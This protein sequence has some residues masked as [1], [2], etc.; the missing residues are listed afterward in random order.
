MRVS[1]S[2]RITLIAALVIIVGGFGYLTYG[3]VGDN[4]VY[5]LTPAELLAK[6]PAAFD[7]PVRL[8]GMVVP[9]SVVWDADKLD[10]RFRLTDGAGTVLVH[11]I[12]APPQMFRGN[13][14]VVVEGKYGPSGV[15][16]SHNLMVKHSNE[17]HPP[18][19]GEKPSDMYRTLQKG[20]S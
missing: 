1:R 12:G 2:R 16:E 20:G 13:I 5:F 8:G 11:A 3:G 14:G 7:T 17:Y 10:L 15:F 6:G 18:K 9:K 4:L 19:P